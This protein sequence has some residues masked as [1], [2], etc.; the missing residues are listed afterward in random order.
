MGLFGLNGLIPG[1]HNLLVISGKHVWPGFFVWEP[2]LRLPPDEPRTATRTHRT[3]IRTARAMSCPPPRT[4]WRVS[5]VG[6][7]VVRWLMAHGL[8]TIWRGF[9]FAL[10]ASRSALHFFYHP[11]ISPFGGFICTFICQIYYKKRSARHRGYFVICTKRRPNFVRSRGDRLPLSSVPIWSYGITLTRPFLGISPIFSFEKDEVC[12]SRGA[13]IP[14]I[15]RGTRLCAQ[16]VELCAQKVELCD[17]R[18]WALISVGCSD[19]AHHGQKKLCSAGVD[20]LALNRD[21]GCHTMR[22]GIGD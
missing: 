10:L 8:C 16:K 21:G 1:I 12:W 2:R 3:R 11:S 20:G 6:V 13:N 17:S 4:G 14:L 9:K 22:I 15:S 7:R 5:G 18:S 19:G